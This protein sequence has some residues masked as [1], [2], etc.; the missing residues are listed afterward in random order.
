MPE[1]K[2]GSQMVPKWEH[3][4]LIITSVPHTTWANGCLPFARKGK[5]SQSVGALITVLEKN[6]NHLKK[7]KK[8]VFTR[9]KEFFQTTFS[10]TI[11]FTKWSCNA[12]CRAKQ[13]V[14]TF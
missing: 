8:C 11:Y 2:M 3:E 7:L 12:T 5:K 9:A 4:F 10:Q 6:C 1:V 13:W 14:W